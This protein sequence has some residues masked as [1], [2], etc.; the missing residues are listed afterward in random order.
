[1]TPDDAIALSLDHSLARVNLAAR[2]RADDPA[3][4]ASARARR[5]EARRARAAAARDGIDAVAWNDPRFP[6]ALLE[7]S[8]HPAALWWRGDAAAARGPAV[9]LVGSRAASPAALEMAFSL[10]FDLAVRGVV[11]VS[12]LARGVDSA[13]HRGA[14]DA[15]RT[16]AVLGSGLDRLY[17][18]EH[19]GLAAA[20]ARS[21]LV[22]T[23]HPPGTPPLAFHFP[24]R[25][26][27]ISGLARAV[28]VV[29]ASARSG[30]LI[31]AAAALDQGREVMAVPG[32]ALGAGNR[33]AHGL[34]RDGAKIVE[35]ADDIVEELW[36]PKAGRGRGDTT[37]TESVT[38]GDPVLDAMEP[39]EGYELAVLARRAG[40]APAALLP[41]LTD[42]ELAGRVR[43]AAGGRFLRPRRPC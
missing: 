14:L 9:A 30:A 1:M 3:L 41:R 21:G 22:L 27:I 37:S 25:N 2:L 11:V 24:L 20:I 16:I 8:D 39:G 19:Q 28:V 13:A 29:E 7:T 5:D 35:C 17:P 18:P 38:C 15:G 32:C 31:T 36:E 10:A 12:G 42:L 33:G 4:R 40:L 43:R 34:I 23:E 6:P 26:H